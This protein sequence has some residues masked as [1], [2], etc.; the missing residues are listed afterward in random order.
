MTFPITT[1]TALKWSFPSRAVPPA[2][3]D[4]RPVQ[5]RIEAQERAETLSVALMQPH[6][7]GNDDPKLSTPLG[8]FCIVQR[9]RGELYQAGDQYAEVLR[10]AKAARGFSVPYSPR[11]EGA[12]GLTEGQLQAMRDAAIIR[13]ANCNAILIAIHARAARVLEALCYDQREIS[14][15]D[16]ALAAH[17]LLMLAREAFGLINEGINRGK[18]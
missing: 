11:G 17:G 5:E 13:E 4:R 9:L 18:A 7:A 8:R 10:Q 12:T 16:E 1:A 3:G 6:R 2:K 14:V 15:H